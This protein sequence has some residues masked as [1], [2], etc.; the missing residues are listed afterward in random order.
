MSEFKKIQVIYR[1]SF[2]KIVDL[3]KHIQR[4]FSIKFDTE[5]ASKKLVH[6]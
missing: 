2:L 4:P 5:G 3:K 1:Q 6:V